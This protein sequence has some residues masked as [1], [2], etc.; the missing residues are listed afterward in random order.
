MRCWNDQPYPLRVSY[1]WFITFLCFLV[2]LHMNQIDC[3]IN[4]IDS[5]A[6][7]LLPPSHPELGP[8]TSHQ[9]SHHQSK[10]SVPPS[11]PF[12]LLLSRDNLGTRQAPFR[13]IASEQSIL[14]IDKKKKNPHANPNSPLPEQRKWMNHNS[15]GLRWLPCLSH[16]PGRNQV[17]WEMLVPPE[18]VFQYA[19]ST[20][21]LKVQD[22]P[23]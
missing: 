11:I 13:A 4:F 17:L 7:S 23:V 3:V 10:C 12:S 20:Y 22:T 21:W 15:T 6:F 2:I 9:A 19:E 14:K 16:S 18:S 5:I 8:P 1:Y